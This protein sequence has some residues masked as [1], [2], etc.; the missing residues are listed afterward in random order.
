MLIDPTS[1][2]YSNLTISAEMVNMIFK[3][4]SNIYEL[5]NNPE[6]YWDKDKEPLLGGILLAKLVFGPENQCN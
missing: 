4:F 2:I 1:Y 5:L 6:S 3:R